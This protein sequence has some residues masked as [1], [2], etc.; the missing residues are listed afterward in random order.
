M[1]E[2]NVSKGFE[3][4]SQRNNIICPNSSCGPTNFIQAFEYSGWQWDNSMFPEL[5]QPEDKLTKFCRTN[6]DVLAYYENHYGNMYKN[7][8]NEAKELA[9]KQN[10][11]I[12]EVECINSYPPNEAHD[13]MSY[14]ANL[15]LGYTAKDLEKRG[16]RPVTR[17]Y[18]EFDEREVIWQLCGKG[19]PIISSVDPFSNGGG[20][21]ITI[22]GFEAEDS[23]VKPEEYKDRLKI[24][25]DLIKEY[26]IDNTY[27]RFDFKNKK[28]VAVSGDDE[29]IERS[30]LLEI[31]KPVSHYF[32]KGAATCC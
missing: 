1:V 15:F 3:N 28:Y 12:W 24:D 30:K 11:E 5:T 13:V 19:V 17:F 23:F 29:H 18:N 2:I 26:I 7:W 10:K 20:H 31:V 22:V 8:Q 21:Y 32:T 25:L 27:G 4:Y 9:K 16:R 14:A 6:K